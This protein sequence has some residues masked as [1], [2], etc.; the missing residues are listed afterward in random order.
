MLKVGLMWARDPRVYL[1]P[2]K[3]DTLRPGGTGEGSFLSS[4]TALAQSRAAVV[5]GS[6]EGGG[7]EAGTGFFGR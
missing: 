7:P 3:L 5:L 6:A 4:S 2:S 1:R